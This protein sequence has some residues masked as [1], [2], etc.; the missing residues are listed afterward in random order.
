LQQTCPQCAFQ[1]PPDFAFCP[2]CG[3]G[4]AA[5][6]PS[7]A[8]V[9]TLD[10]LPERIRRL[11]PQ[12]YVD[13]LLAAGG[14][15]AGERRLVTILF[16]DIKGSTAMAERLDPEEVMEVMNGAFDVLIEPAMRY[17]GTL[18]RLMG[19]A[20]L[21]F[22]GAPLAHEDDPERACRAALEIVDGAR[23]YAER[24]E[25]ERGIEGFNVRV[26]INTGLVVVGEV[27]SDLRV[28]YTAMGDAIN[29]A[30]RMEQNAPIGGILI[31]H[32]TYRHVRGVFDVLPQEPLKV[33]GRTDPVHTY[34]VQRAKPRAF[35]K[36]VRGV[37]GIETRMIGRQAELTRLQEAF[38]TAMEDG[39]LQMVTV[40]GD[41]G[42][43]KSRL[44][45]EFD[46]WS[47]LLP[48]TF[49][50]FKGRALQEMQSVPYS[51]LRSL[52]AFRFQIEDTDALAMVR[53]KLER[54]VRGALGD[55]KETQMPAHRAAHFIGHLVGFELGESPHLA[56]VP[57]DRKQVH[58]RALTHLVEYFKALAAEN[59]VLMLLEDL[60]WADDSSLDV[61][62]H[63]SLALTHQP[64]MIASAARPALFERRPHWGEGQAFHRRLPLEPLT[65]RNTRRLLGEILQKVEAVPDTLSDLVVAG[66]EGN[67]FFVE[68]LIKML[69]EDG[70]IVKGEE[71]WHVEPARLS[72]VR[73]PP[74]LRGVLQA[75]LDRLPVEDR[76][77]LQQASVVG[78]QFWDRTVVHISASAAEGVEEGEVLDTLSDLRAREMVFQRE[79]TAFT[80]AQEY[81]FKHN[82][83]REVTYR[84]LL[85]R[86]RRVYH[87]LVADWL[88]EQGGE[89]ANEYT[90][91]IADHL[92]LAGRHPEAIE[93][94]LQAGDRARGLYAHQEAIGAY[95]RALALQKELGDDER[96]ART[97]MKLGL[98]YHSTF[99]FQ[100]SHRAYEEA[101]ALW[102]RVGE[103]P[104]EDLQPAPHPLRVGAT[105]PL[106]LDPTL[107]LDTASDVVIRQLFS[108][109]VEMTSESDIVP[110]VASSW[111]VSQAGRRYGFQLR[112]DV[113]WSDGVP[114]TAGDF[115]FAWKRVL[116]PVTD[117]PAASLLYD[118]EGARAFH[119]GLVSDPDS[120]GVRALDELTLEVRLEGPTGY[121]LH[122]LAVSPTYAVPRH[123]V[124]AYDG[125]WTE[126]QNIVVNGPFLLETRRLGE[127]LVLVRNPLYHGRFLGNLRQVELSL[128]PPGEWAAELEAY[129]GD[130]LDVGR[131]ADAPAQAMHR[132]RQAHAGEYVLT[133]TG[134]TQFLV[135]DLTRPPF[136]DRRVRQ[137]FVLALDREA[138]IQKT[139]GGTYLPATGG[140]LPPTIP[141]HTPGIALAFDPARA[142]QLMAEAGYPH[143]QDFPTVRMLT[144]PRCEPQM[145]YMHAQWGEALGVT[146]ACEVLEWAEYLDTLSSDRPHIYHMGWLADYPDPDTFL[147]VALRRHSRW[148]HE[149][150]DLL[151]ER[152]RRATDQRE[153]TEIYQQA[154]RI[155]VQEAPLLPLC[156]EHDP[157]LV[158]PWVS[159]YPVSVGFFLL[160]KDVIIEPH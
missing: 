69:V 7:A 101:F 65:K 108:G 98:A 117:S 132:A 68:E 1:A 134:I 19:D 123:V 120:V 102:Q 58:D 28:E 56:D 126:T 16:S 24:L 29:L 110:A 71:R 72:E 3:A 25:Q 84:S 9:P 82:V 81:V 85:K 21:A 31:A 160:W 39:E 114:V 89:R 67:P 155:L 119:Q 55:A 34:L 53:E 105:E 90:G 43:G 100:R 75:R 18:A 80:G 62:N 147:R 150:Y 111:E 96:A 36:G 46:L 79:T 32:D 156:Y 5:P 109:L 54:G 30:A 57:D 45:H 146:T 40:V 141:G 12:E 103:R 47:E 130:R 8:A 64:L 60:H 131:L 104:T 136:H 23:A 37:E 115:E 138:L 59:P 78:R 33:K 148:R 113:R 4:L 49:Y 10:T 151:V 121:F 87:G 42:V 124:R 125:A 107:S 6:K 15:M 157:L 41:A 73:V 140:F 94:L 83:L 66:A 20:V 143:G 106:T 137:A 50:F 48:E 149:V 154:D 26:G 77:V 91:L 11:M 70:V 135:F 86:L 88:L 159:K 95:E 61:L 145:E 99:D 76:A 152:A 93:Y 158:K 92:E 38:Y 44:L 27:G 52:F 144:W 127:R 13:R 2:K 17:E 116:D 153:R 22:F 14:Q 74:T 97:L 51:L 128:F 139:G 118:V 122:L 35:R 129:E 142:R 63:L 112:E 133:P